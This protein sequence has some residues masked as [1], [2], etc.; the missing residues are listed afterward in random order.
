MKLTFS[1]ALTLSLA[2]SAIAL[3]E[4]KHPCPMHEKHQK[5]DPPP[6]ADGSH[7]HGAAVDARHDT[8][9]MSHASSRHNFRLFTDGGA[10]ELRALSETDLRT[11][12]KIREHLSEIVSDFD[13]GDYSTPLFV[14]GY[15]PHGTETMARLTPK[16]EFRYADLPAGGRIR[17]TTN[18]REAVEAIHAFMKFQIVEHRTGESLEVIEEK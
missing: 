6:A 3:A 2:V 1:L 11:I 17:L 13:E 15:T 10:I 14:H 18:D 4:E 12:A 16:I 5:K 8:F 9:G 7:E